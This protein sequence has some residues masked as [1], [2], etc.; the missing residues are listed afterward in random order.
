MSVRR[1]AVWASK[2]L[3]DLSLLTA[4]FLLAC[5]IRFEGDV[6]PFVVEGLGVTLP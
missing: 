1:H 4:S 2:V 6:P 3:L 5:L